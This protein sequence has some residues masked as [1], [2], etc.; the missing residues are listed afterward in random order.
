MCVGIRFFGASWCVVFVNTSLMMFKGS[1]RNAKNGTS[2]HVS[3]APRLKPAFLLFISF[4][5][6]DSQPPAVKAKISTNKI[7]SNRNDSVCL[8]EVVENQ[9]APRVSVVHRQV[10]GVRVGVEEAIFTSGHSQLFHNPIWINLAYF[11]WSS[12]LAK[13]T[14]LTGGFFGKTKRQKASKYAWAKFLANNVRSKPCASSFLRYVSVVSEVTATKRSWKAMKLRWIE[15]FIVCSYY[16][17]LH[18]MSCEN[19]VLL[20]HETANSMSKWSRNPAPKELLLGSSRIGLESFTVAVF[21]PSLTC[22]N[23]TLWSWAFSIVHVQRLWWQ[24]RPLEQPVDAGKQI[25]KCQVQF[26]RSPRQKKWYFLMVESKLNQC[27]C[28]NTTHFARQSHFIE[29]IA[30]ATVATFVETPPFRPILGCVVW[31]FVSHCVPIL[32]VISSRFCWFLSALC[33]QYHMVSLP[34]HITITSLQASHPPFVACTSIY[35]YIY[36]PGTVDAII[37]LLSQ[38]NIIKWLRC[39]ISQNCHILAA[40]THHLFIYDSLYHINVLYQTPKSYYNKSS[41]LAL[42]TLSLSYI[43][44]TP[45]LEIPAVPIPLS[46][47]RWLEVRDLGASHKSQGQD[48]GCGELIDHLAPVSILVRKPCHLNTAIKKYPESQLSE[49]INQEMAQL[50]QDQ[51]LGLVVHFRSCGRG[52][53]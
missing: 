15:Y 22:I 14:V 41:S 2:L 47:S 31:C 28:M 48:F 13:K 10:S 35:I 1:W 7:K 29:L 52:Q 49:T 16:M 3:I 36:N 46:A 50:A 51:A 26:D 37:S 21:T 8:P 24:N 38:I 43:A 30:T 20:H 17:L 11:C 6:G 18:V 5:Y 9:A 39:R 42:L 12:L 19:A 27:W 34:R 40:G 44:V 53:T 23:W 32:A 45:L 33:G 4:T 25:W